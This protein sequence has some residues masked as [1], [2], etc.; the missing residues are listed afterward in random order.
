MVEEIL[1][2]ARATTYDFR[3]TAYPE[4][5]LR[6][7]F[8]EWVPYY[9]TKWAIA[10]V[11]KP[12]SILEIGVRYGYSALA[13]LDAYP[14][15][16]YLGI[17]LDAPS[18]GGSV[19]AIDWAREACSEYQAEMIIADSTKMDRFPGDR[20]DLIHIDGQQDEQGTMHDLVRAAAQACYI[21]VDGFFWSRSNFLSASE[22]L[23]R[24][25]Q[26]IEFYEVV[27]GYA[28]DLLVKVKENASGRDLS[29][30][31]STGLGNAIARDYYLADEVYNRTVRIELENACLEALA[32]LAGTGPVKRALYLGCGRGK[33][34]LE[35]EQRGFEVT[36]IND[37]KDD[38]SIAGE[39][40]S[41]GQKL[42][43]SIRFRSDEIKEIMF[44]GNYDIA[45]AVDLIEHLE[46]AELDQLYQR[47]AEHLSEDGLFILHTYPNLWFYR[48]E[49]RR[50][51]RKA[52]QIGAYL[53]VEPRSRYELLEHINEQSPRVL[54]R[55]LSKYF[56]DVRVW[57]GS[58]DRPT[59]NLER[60]FS[61]GEMR[62]S[63]DLFAVASRSPISIP[64]LLAEF[65]MERLAQSDWKRLKLTVKSHPVTVRTG[66][67]FTVAIQLRNETLADIRSAEPYPV[68]LSYHWLRTNG[69]HA[70]FDGERTRIVPE[71]RSGTSGIFEMNVAAPDTAG[72]YILKA[73]LV[74]EK[75]GWFDQVPDG[76]SSDLQISCT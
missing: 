45:L 75:I 51:V 29:M 38:V 22:F 14:S 54:R 43:S 65:R 55:Q 13:F 9:R 40:P 52:S 59:E 2:V 25:R 46:S 67:K 48:Y 57:F 42:R 12:N 58:P 16:R 18:F 60:K 5:P 10:K 32:K 61:I 30:G 26:I 72:S 63:P 6:H 49:H 69:K 35:L 19:G 50:R 1:R 68:N 53:P 74:Q 33:L 21:L 36:T 23:F 15:A 11:L 34:S 28:G 70:I 3:K 24:Y 17:D 31:T 4:D 66:S 20:Y 71:L 37:S 64:R 56:Q 62:S 73:T 39:I 27:P 44:D 76:P 7:L 47:I 8:P 41:T